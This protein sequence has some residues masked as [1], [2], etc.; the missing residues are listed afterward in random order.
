MKRN[1]QKLMI[2]ISK[3]KNE[4]FN[5]FS[6]DSKL[7]KHLP[8]KPILPENNECCGQG[9]RRCVFDLYDEKMEKYEREMEE[10]NKGG[11]F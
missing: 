11:T 1:Y 2:K 3:T 4:I 10:Y 9:C 7:K 8:I 5:F 6:N